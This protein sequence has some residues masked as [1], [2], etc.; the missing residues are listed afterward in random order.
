MTEEFAFHV[1]VSPTFQGNTACRGSHV[2]W[3][4][5]ARFRLAVIAANKCADARIVVGDHRDRSGQRHRLILADKVFSHRH[6]FILGRHAL[7]TECRALCYRIA[8]INGSTEA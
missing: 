6:V 5:R 8:I 7:K 2:S 4:Q 1:A 3:A